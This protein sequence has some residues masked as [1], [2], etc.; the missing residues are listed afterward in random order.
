M[1]DNN[2]NDKNTAKMLELKDKVTPA[3]MCESK[4][5]SQHRQ[6]HRSPLHPIVQV[7]I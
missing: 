7:Q 3:R 4:A 2:H 1:L 6:H 5:H